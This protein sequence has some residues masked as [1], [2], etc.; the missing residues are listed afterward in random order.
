M[1]TSRP[2]LSSLSPTVFFVS[3]GLVVLLIAYAALDPGGAQQVFSVAQAW[4]TAEVGWIYLLAVGAFLIFLLAIAASGFGAVRLGPDDSS[5]D[6]SFLTWVAMLFSAG[7][8]IGLVFYGV[9]EPITHYSVPPDDAPRSIQAARHAMQITFFHWGLH[10][11]AIYAVVGLALAYFGFRQGLPLTI[12]S[13]FYPLL[14]DRIHGPV[15]HAID[16]FAIVGTLCGLAVSLGLGVTQ[17]NASL[18]FL[19]GVPQTAWI[20]VA[21]IAGITALATISVVT[22]LDTGIRRLSEANLLLAALL[23]ALVLLLGPTTFLLKAFVENIGLYLGGVVSRTFHIYAYQPTDWIGSWTIFYWGWWISWSPFVGMFIARISRGRTIREFLTGVLF[24][25]T[26]FAFL[27]FTVFG[28]TAIWLDL[29]RATGAIS[30][31]VADDVSVAIF[32]MFDYLPLTSVLSVLATVLVAIFFVTSAD[33]GALVV[34]MIASGGHED[35][36]IWQRV[37]WSVSAGL[38]AAVLLLAGGLAAL[39]TAT[40]ASALPFV[41]IML[42]MCV[43]IWRGLRDEAHQR[44]SLSLPLVPM[45]GGP[46]PWQQR[47]AAIASHP[48]ADRVRTYLRGTVAEALGTAAAE[49]ERRGLRAEVEALEDGSRLTVS[50]GDGADYVYAVRARGYPMPV[51]AMDEPKKAGEQQTTYYRAEVFLN[52]GGRGYDIYGHTADQVIADIVNHYD[53]YRHYLHVTGA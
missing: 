12:R 24:V 51:F 28:D 8:G 7:M 19:L 36:P 32:K 48:S 22:G 4:I 6:Y 39:Q 38:M 23:V 53:R 26:G 27:W 49:F 13:A 52:Q 47:L 46:Q 41:I 29:G 2:W 45:I 20:Q 10:A 3:A 21:L 43:G 14:G 11:W 37:F 35:P 15:G 17:I 50:H 31:A 9:A 44:E 33:S 42:A 30:D 34:G 1:T 25:P 16:V 18:L 5:P 40:I